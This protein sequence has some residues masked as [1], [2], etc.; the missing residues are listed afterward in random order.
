MDGVRLKPRSKIETFV[1]TA[2]EKVAAAGER[3][4]IKIRFSLVASTRVITAAIVLLVFGA[5]VLVAGIARGFGV[6][7]KI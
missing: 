4:G 5:A 2:L 3:C 7:K 6:G 1:D